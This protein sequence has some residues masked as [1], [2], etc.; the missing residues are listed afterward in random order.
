MISNGQTQFAT[1]FALSGVS[2][3]LRPLKLARSHSWDQFFDAL[4][5]SVFRRAL[6]LYLPI[7]AV[8][9]C[10]LLVKLLGLSNNAHRLRYAWP[11]GGTNDVMHVV[12]NSN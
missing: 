12:F 8:Q 3:S 6:R 7:L 2:L 11:Y 9:T 4:F 5:S 10:V 1:F